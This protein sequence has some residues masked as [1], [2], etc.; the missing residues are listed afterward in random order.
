MANF[1]R[2]P[3]A[4]HTQLYW[5]HLIKSCDINE[6]SLSFNIIA[7]QSFERCS[8][9]S[10]SCGELSANGQ[11]S[12]RFMSYASC[13]NVLFKTGRFV[14]R[15]WK[16]SGGQFYCAACVLEF[17]WP[18]RDYGAGCMQWSM[19]FL[20]CVLY[21]YDFA[22]CFSATAALYVSKILAF[23]FCE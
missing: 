22:F 9:G 10:K 6:S 1:R 4:R 15:I 21:F 18:Q 8:S 23:E 17:T 11:L 20:L 7:N 14:L 19:A 2:N 12:T 13:S 16:K 3:A 5:Y